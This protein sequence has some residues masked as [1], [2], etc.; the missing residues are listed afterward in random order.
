[1][2]T[3]PVLRNGDPVSV[4]GGQLSAH[5][6]LSEP[7]TV[8]AYTLNMRIPRSLQLIQPTASVHMYQRCHNKEYYLQEPRFKALY[9]Q[10]VLESLKQEVTFNKV[11]ITSYCIMGNHLHSGLGYEDSFEYLSRF[12]RHSNSLFGARYNRLNKRSGKVSESR[13]K[14]TL[15]ENLEHEMRA[16]FYIEANQ[17]R[18]RIS[19]PENLKLQKFNSFKFTCSHI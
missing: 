1:M 14:T 7:W 17:I 13:P 16:H 5:S 8:F 2:G 15:I 18:A 19:T 3:D 11:K 12:M 6:F 9:M 4:F 10:A